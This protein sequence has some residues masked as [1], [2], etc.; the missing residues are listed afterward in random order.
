M[1]GLAAITAN[2][3]WAMAY[4][5]AGIVMTGLSILAFIIYQLPKIVGLLEKN[6]TPDT[7]SLDTEVK[8]DLKIKP[9][10]VSLTDIEQTAA[11]YEPL[12]EQLGQPFYLKDLYV[13]AAKHKFPHPHLTIKTFREKGKIVSDGEGMFFWDPQGTVVS[14]K[15]SVAATPVPVPADPVAPAVAEPAQPPTSTPAPAAPKEPAPTA[16]GSGTAI[17]APMPGMI[18]RYEKQIGDTVNEG[19]TVVIL[20]AMKMENV[21]PAPV[22]GTITSIH[23][24]SGDTAAKDD[25]L[26]VIG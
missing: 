19:D 5:G 14:K 3:G 9:P 16:T 22:S 2:N 25:V 20:E 26:C 10:E 21:L 11:A 6:K 15:S 24:T 13:L 18:V 17:T 8:A 12:I 1:T 7:A 4:T 23:F